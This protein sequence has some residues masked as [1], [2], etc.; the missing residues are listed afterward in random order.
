MNR[1]FKT[2]WSNS[3]NSFIAVS[4]AC[5]TRC[6]ASP[7]QTIKTAVI[8]ALSGA[9]LLQGGLAF[10]EQ[11]DNLDAALNPNP[12]GTTI[13]HTDAY[14]IKFNDG[15]VYTIDNFGTIELI[16][17]GSINP[18]YTILS[19]DDDDTTL[20]TLTNNSGATISASET[21]GHGST[22]AAIYFESGQVTSLVNSGSISTTSSVGISVAYLNGIYNDA[23]IGTLNNALGG[24]I[25]VSGRGTSENVGIYNTGTINSLINFGSITVNQ[26]TGG[27]T[28]AAIYNSGTITSLTNSGTI[29]TTVTG[30]SVSLASAIR[31]S[32]GTINTLINNGTI[33]TTVTGTSVSL[34]SAI[35]SRNSTI[36]TLNNNGTIST[37]VTATGSGTAI[38]L[39]HNNSG[40]SGAATVTNTSTGTIS[41]TTTVTGSEAGGTAWGIYNKGRTITDLTN[42]G[43][44]SASA[45]GA[46]ASVSVYAVGIRNLFGGEITTLTN[47][48]TISATST[49]TGSGEIS[50]NSVGIYNNGSNATIGTITNT[51][52]ISGDISIHNQRTPGGNEVIGTLNNL[53]SDLTYQGFLPT[54][55]NIIIRGDANYGQTTF[56]LSSGTTTFGIDLTNSGADIGDQTYEDVLKGDFAEIDL[57]NGTSGVIEGATWALSFDGANWDLTINGALSGL[58]GPAGP[59]AADTQTSIQA[60]KGQLQGNLNSLTAG[61]NF[62]NMN[63][64]DCNFFDSKGGCFSFGNRYTD[65]QSP[66]I[67]TNSFVATGGYKLND[68]FRVAGFIDQNLNY[69]MASNIDIE[70]K[71][72]LMGLIGVWNQNANQLGWQIKLANAY[73][74]KDARITRSVTGSSEAGRGQTDIDSQSYVAELS[75]SHAVSS[76]LL[77]QPYAALRYAVVEQD[78]YTETG[79]ANPL[80]FNTIR[81]RSKTS[82]VG[83]KFKKQLTDKVVARG[84]VGLEHDLSHKTDNLLASG[85]AG[86]TTESFSNQLDKTRLVASLGADY[87]IDPTQRLS[88]NAFYQELPFAST[89]ARTLYLNY[90][91]A[92]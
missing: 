6:K 27:S 24:T 34:A 81:D 4:E 14:T 29:S 18:N 13:S 22:V 25:S 23:T 59:S 26:L 2:V 76:S 57:L 72:P 39:Y 91:L 61:A 21:V 16:G 71:G 84:S 83:G 40:L 36:N 41:A 67:Q 68:H 74:S 47:T 53:Q 49:V 11:I 82:L 80:T 64:Y 35:Y 19:S 45:S 73:Q 58:Y 63:T 60:I 3:S 48:G 87:Y 8:A 88:V 62:A 69:N 31:L 15:G 89:K 1:S 42:A 38:G 46:G 43:T 44:I 65:V 30:N 51:G 9:S 32:S 70:N 10:A 17:S 55:Y 7:A 90:M 20:T 66:S 54:N 75:Y 86:L 85:V 50:A 92:F 78:G 5:K 56:S 33:S 37:T 77:L 12:V 79:V 28:N 52:I